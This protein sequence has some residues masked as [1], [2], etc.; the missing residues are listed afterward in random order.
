MS[1][2]QILTRPFRAA[3]IWSTLAVGA[4]YLYIF[5]PGKSGFFPACPFRTLTGFTCPACGS[6]RGLH[7]LLHGDV[8]AAFQFNPLLVLAL[9]FLLYALVRYTNAAFRDRPLKPHQL[10]AKYIW[11]VCIIVLSFW[12]FRNTA[13]YPFPI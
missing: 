2:S 11:A 9:P 1:L 10:N 6:T 3:L 13:V 12:V 4:A 7:R 5:E 8:V